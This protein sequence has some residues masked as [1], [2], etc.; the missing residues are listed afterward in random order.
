MKKELIQKSIAFGLL[1]A[2]ASPVYAAEFG[3]FGD[4]TY[5]DSNVPGV[6]S[7]FSIGALDF[8]ASTYIADDTQVF[9][10][11]VFEDGGTGLVTDLER[12]WIGH[13]F[14]DE[15]KLSVGR[16]HTPLG[17]WNRS[18]HH[19]ALLQDT[20]SRP[21]FLDFEDGAAGILPVHIV[22][23]LAS[24]TFTTDSGDINYELYAANGSSIDSTVAGFAATPTNKP[25]L[26]INVASD[27]NNSKMVGARVTYSFD[28][29]PLTVG[30]MFLNNIIAESGDDTLVPPTLVPTGESLIDQQIFGFDV[31][32]D[33]E[34]YLLLAEY[35]SLVNDS[36]VGDKQSHTGTAY[37]VQAG[38]KFDENNRV[39]YRHASLDFDAADSYF[40][41]LGARQATHD[42]L[43]YRYDVDVT[44]AI[45]FEVNRNNPDVGS[46][47]T[48][49]VVQWSFLVP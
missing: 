26:D 27:S 37:Y 45:K 4:V 3:L 1:I 28:D 19:G 17:V 20:V 44:N 15:L 46:S 39:I 5:S 34:H 36:N 18:Y 33:A 35:Y 10:E 24:G 8:Y 42:V 12:L 48:R 21:F 40:L 32:Y 22:G 2:S 31:N 49:Y 47:D 29:L 16:F 14:R 9:V 11:Y 25:E 13:T 23:A 6:N 43:A 30:G 38:Y 41:L 7:G